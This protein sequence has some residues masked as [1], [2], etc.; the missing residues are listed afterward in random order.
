[1]TQRLGLIVGVG[2][3]PEIGESAR[4]LGPVHDAEAMADL[5]LRR[6]G[7]RRGHIQVLLNAEA[8][9][10]DIL[11]ALDAMVDA[12]RPED[13]VLFHFSGHGS[14]LRDQDGHEPDGLDETLV[15]FD[16]HRRPGQP[17]ADIRDDEIFERLARL[18]T[19]RAFA[20]VIFDCCHSGHAHRARQGLRIRALPPLQGAP[21]R[22]GGRLFAKR[23]P[24]RIVLA[25][26]RDDQLAGE[27]P[28]GRDRFYGDW[29]WALLRAFHQAQAPLTAGA[30]FDHAAGLLG[31]TNPDQWPQ[32]LGERGQILFGAERLPTTPRSFVWRDETRAWRLDAGAIHG[33]QPGARWALLAERDSP[34]AKRLAEAEVREVGAFRSR[35]VVEGSDL[36]GV[37]E[38]W[39]EEIEPAYG[40]GRLLV[41]TVD[42][43][44]WVIESRTQLESLIDRSPVLRRISRKTAQKTESLQSD[45][46]V[47]PDLST[48]LP[49]GRHLTEPQSFQ[50]PPAPRAIVD[51]LEMR[52]RARHGLALENLDPRS[53]LNPAGDR[54]RLSPYRL[55]Q[56]SKWQ[57]LAVQHGTIRVAPGDLL[58]FE[59]QHQ[60]DRGLYVYFLD[61]GLTDRISLL[62]PEP[63][64]GEC[65]QPGVSLN[66]GLRPGEELAVSWPSEL[67]TAEGFGFLKVFA[68]TQPTN[69]LALT[70]AQTA[71]PPSQRTASRLESLLAMA[72]PSPTRYLYE[73]WTTC[74]LGLHVRA[75]QLHLASR[76]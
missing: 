46:R 61:F 35:L 72:P 10:A 51:R 52:A 69:F 26:C 33:L 38:A 29:S 16:G 56:S 54:L 42:S 48:T 15:P 11:F 62:Y 55:D 8:K 74:R 39:A 75:Q 18:E 3:Y 7:F 5:L 70:T 1:M 28:V 22:T 73:D 63:G 76:D 30:L 49:H 2:E 71:A 6:F 47:W 40:D 34:A 43:E 37:E 66:L 4:L 27:G 13:Q 50:D 20:T 59:L 32:L 57:P 60:F 23:A 45:I 44:G 21:R 14:Q 58:R 12:A 64:A 41:E 53:A 17:P 67:K 65:L 25:A 68:S 24:R 31:Y 19:K 9:R 36:G